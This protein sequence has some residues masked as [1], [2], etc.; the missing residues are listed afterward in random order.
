M[1]QIWLLLIVTVSVMCECC[2]VANIYL[3]VVNIR[4]EERGEFIDQPTDGVCFFFVD[5]TMCLRGTGE[6]RF[7]AADYPSA[8]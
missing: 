4:V 7:P 6:R 5:L 1:I 8:N 2:V 3:V